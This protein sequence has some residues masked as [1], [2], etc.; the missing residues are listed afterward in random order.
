MCEFKGMRGGGEEPYL[1]PC[2]KE[3]MSWLVVANGRPAW[4]A[5]NLFKAVKAASNAVS[6]LAPLSN[7]WSTTERWALKP[8]STKGMLLSA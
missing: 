4:A 3:H 8:P 6:R 2:K 5:T 1:S 7:N